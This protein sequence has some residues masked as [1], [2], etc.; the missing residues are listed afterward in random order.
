MS[1]A[2]PNAT[3][4]MKR[5]QTDRGTACAVARHGEEVRGAPE[6]ADGH[7]GLPEDEI[8]I[9]D[10]RRPRS[11]RCAPTSKGAPVPPVRRGRSV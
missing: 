6:T 11:P 2:A 1:W 3:S 4:T 9:I 8:R 5:L 7:S 10:A